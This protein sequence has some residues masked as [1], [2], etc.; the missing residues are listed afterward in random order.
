MISEVPD[1]VDRAAI[2]FEEQYADG[3]SESGYDS[4]KQFTVSFDLK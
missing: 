1:E 2:F 3:G 4:G